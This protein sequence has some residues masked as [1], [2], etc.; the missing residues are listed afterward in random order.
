MI[1]SPLHSDASSSSKP[2]IIAPEMASS[3]ED[4]DTKTE[5]FLRFGNFFRLLQKNARDSATVIQLL[6]LT[7]SSTMQLLSIH[8]ETS[9][10]QPLDPLG[11]P[12]AKNG[13]SN[14]A[15][16][17]I[18]QKGECQVPRQLQRN[19]CFLGCIRIYKVGWKGG[20]VNEF[21]TGPGL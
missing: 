20:W 11:E 8:S 6:P 12:F 5:C 14:S 1:C 21:G 7:D 9:I 17:L 3:K 2:N 15:T 13:T 19:N 4:S 18:Q 16:G 10:Q